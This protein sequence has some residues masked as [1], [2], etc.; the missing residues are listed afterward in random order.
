M[1]T[2]SI[3]IPCYKRADWLK[4]TL[5]SVLSQRTDEMEIITV[6]QDEVDS[7]TLRN[8]CKEHRVIYIFSDRPSTPRSRNLGVEAAHGEVLIFFDDDVELFDGC[9]LAHLANYQDETVVAVGGRVVTIRENG[10]DTYKAAADPIGWVNQSGQLKGDRNYNSGS[11]LEARTTPL[12]CNMSVRARSLKKVGGFDETY[13]GNALREETDPIL[14]MIKLGGKVI[15][16]PKAGVKHF[17]AKSGGSRAKPK[18]QWYLDFFFNNCYFYQK[19]VSPAWRPIAYLS[20]TPYLLKYW[21]RWSRSLADFWKPFQ[22][23]G[24]ARLAHTRTRSN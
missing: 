21:F 13:V 18:D 3:I 23:A 19:F 5:E 9:L 11:R 7:P 12:G 15:F 16:D 10:E 24:Q 1:I 4:R 2:T 14:R 22:V 8:W 17:L 20:L 6:F